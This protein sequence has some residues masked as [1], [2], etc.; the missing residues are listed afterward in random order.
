MTDDDSR[1]ECYPVAPVVGW[2]PDKA[3]TRRRRAFIERRNLG[4]AAGG[5]Q[6]ALEAAKG[7]SIGAAKAAKGGKS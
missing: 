3:A 5:A 7:G 1:N 6:R 2:Q 4:I